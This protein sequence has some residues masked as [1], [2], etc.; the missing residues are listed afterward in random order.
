MRVSVQDYLLDPAMKR[1]EDRCERP[2][3]Q[4]GRQIIV[5]ESAIE[6]NLYLHD[7]TRTGR[8]TRS[9][10]SRLTDRR[11]LLAQQRFSL[12]QHLRLRSTIRL[13][14]AFSIV[15]KGFF[16]TTKPSYEECLLLKS[17]TT[18][19]LQRGGIQEI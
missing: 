4:V 16:V 6:A 19:S 14:T 15:K 3:L 18:I 9:A 5:S 10:T 12:A 17:R 11:H 7:F 13:R 8:T 1:L 2:T